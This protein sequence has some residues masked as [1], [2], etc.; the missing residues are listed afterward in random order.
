M[1]Q[2]QAG[3]AV[4]G[5]DEGQS[6]ASHFLG[7]VPIYAPSPG[8]TAFLRLRLLEVG[9]RPAS[10]CGVDGLKAVSGRGKELENYSNRVHCSGL[11]CLE[12]EALQH[13]PFSCGRPCKHRTGGSWTAHGLVA[14]A[15]HVLGA[16]LARGPVPPGM[17]LLQVR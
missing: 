3:G 6:E 10:V 9:A 7:R 12:T 14:W 2:A 13:A 11:R 1:Y 17:L 15:A 16:P 5:P 8:P 4:E